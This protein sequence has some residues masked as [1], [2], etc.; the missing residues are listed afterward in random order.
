MVVGFP[1]RLLGGVSAL[2]FPEPFADRP[3]A[4]RPLN[5]VR[6]VAGLASREAEPLLLRCC[7]N[8]FAKRMFYLGRFAL[9]SLREDED[10][11]DG[12]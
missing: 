4:D 12:N 5:L 8:G 3:V 2:S 7:L 9:A 6:A 10:D 11:A 1:Q